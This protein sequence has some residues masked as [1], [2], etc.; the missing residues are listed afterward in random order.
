MR[1][2]LIYETILIGILTLLFTFGIIYVLNN[3]LPDSS[4]PDYYKMVI[5][6]F[7]VGALLHL[8]FE[9]TGMNESWCKYTYRI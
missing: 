5:G 9:F 1:D 6:A 4:K 8:S 2:N 3:K 7:S